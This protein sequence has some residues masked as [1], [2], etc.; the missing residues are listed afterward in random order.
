[1]VSIGVSIS[2]IHAVFVCVV[3]YVFMI[4]IVSIQVHNFLQVVGVSGTTAYTPFLMLL[5]GK[6]EV[7]LEGVEIEDV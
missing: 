2:V 7:V 5:M 3:K 1:M 6:L 4:K